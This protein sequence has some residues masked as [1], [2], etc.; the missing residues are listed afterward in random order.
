MAKAE[1]DIG[2]IAYLRVHQVGSGY[3]PP[4]DFIDVECVVKLHGSED[5][6]YG[7]QLRNKDINLEANKGM[8]DLLREA[9]FRKYTVRIEYLI[10]PGKKNGYIFRV[11]LLANEPQL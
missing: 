4:S 9:F 5:Y 7:F 6:A 3:G 1:A 10:E 2:T 11:N 8:L